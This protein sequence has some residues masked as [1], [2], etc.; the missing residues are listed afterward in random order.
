[1]ANKY[2]QIKK[3]QAQT[4]DGWKFDAQHFILWN[5]KEIYTDSETDENGVFYRLS[6]KYDAEATGEGWSRKATGRQVPTVHIDRYTPTD[7]ESVMFSVVWILKKN[8]GEPQSRRNF[9]Y[10]LKLAQ[11]IDTAKLFEEGRAKD[12]GATSNY[13]GQPLAQDEKETAEEATEEETTTETP[14]APY[15]T[16]EEITAAFIADGWT[17]TTAFRD[18]TPEEIT[19]A[20]VWIEQ[21]AERG[22]KFYIMTK[23]GNFYDQNGSIIYYNIHTATEPDEATASQEEP[24]NEPESTT[25][26]TTDGEKEPLNPEELTGVFGEIVKGVEKL[27]EIAS[28]TPEQ[29]A[30]RCEAKTAEIF[31]AKK[32]EAITADIMESVNAI[33]DGADTSETIPPEEVPT[34]DETATGAATE[35]QK[36]AS[37]AAPDMFAELAKAYFTGKTAPA[38]RPKAKKETDPKNNTAEA[39]TTAT[40]DESEPEKPTAPPLK[41]DYGYTG[42]ASD[43]FTTEEIDTLTSGGQVER[44]GKYDRRYIYISAKYNDRTAL[45]Y[46]TEAN[47]GK[48]QPGK[49]LDY[50]GFITGGKFYR[51]DNKGIIESLQA[52]INAAILQKLPTEEAAQ[53]NAEQTKGADSYNMRT[54][55]ELKQREY[56]EEARRKFCMGEEPQLKVYFNHYPES[57]SA[58][59]KYIED[60]AQY[61]EE[62]AA[63][64]IEARPVEILK[65]YIIYNRTA[66]H[67]YNIAA[68]PGNM[69]HQLKRMAAAV[70]DQ[71]TLRIELTDGATIRAE[72]SAIKYIGNRGKIYSCNYNLI[73]GERESRADI[74]P[75]EIKAIYHGQRTLY[76]AA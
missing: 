10:L 26:P 62:R 57:E 49:S 19:A 18:A 59:I 12:T 68:D 1:M 63:E 4:P 41:S 55:E 51:G 48:I 53:A 70:T 47:A 20:G 27:E 2:E 30:A 64:Y 15:K 61:I 13:L 60:P 46:Q 11:T 58:I 23:S 5:E 52:D 37:E 43:T 16:A 76:R 44:I 42:E 25:E 50:C 69:A 34:E 74:M 24:A 8:A 71:K 28:E 33:L 32:V 75:E 66:P 73:D 35:T 36:T 9:N 72:A 39:E 3:A 29:F 21:R 38:I 6:L 31:P 7:E 56:T 54:A 22:E 65:N 17:K 14:K 45:I 40:A 67:Y